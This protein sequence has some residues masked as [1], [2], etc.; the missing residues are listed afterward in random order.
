[1]LRRDN[2]GNRFERAVEICGRGCWT[3]DGEWVDRGE[4]YE[5]GGQ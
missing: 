3:V 4:R 2:R 1:M 5:D